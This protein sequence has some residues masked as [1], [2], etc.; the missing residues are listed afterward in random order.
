[1]RTSLVLV[2]TVFVLAALP[3]LADKNPMVGTWRASSGFQVTIPDSADTFEL[4][5]QR[6]AERVTHPAR[7]LRRGVD[8]TWTDKAG[9]THT[10]SIDVKRADRI[11]DINHAYPDSHAYWYRVK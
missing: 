11:V 4:V 6:G 5:F 9:G 1:M 8:F 10:A 7:W 3:A 2:L